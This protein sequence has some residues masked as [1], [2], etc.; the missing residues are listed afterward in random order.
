MLMNEEQKTIARMIAAEWE[1]ETENWKQKERLLRKAWAEK[2]E[3][4]L[5]WKNE[6]NTVVTIGT[7]TYIDHIK[8]LIHWKDEQGSYYNVSFEQILS[9]EKGRGDS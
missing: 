9:V 7:C 4:R 1:K 8:R 3:L 6:E 5:Y 2:H